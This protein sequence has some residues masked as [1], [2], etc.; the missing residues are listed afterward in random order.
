M[1]NYSTE[2]TELAEHRATL[3]HVDVD[4]QCAITED[5]LHL[6]SLMS[7]S[8]NL[9]VYQLLITLAWRKARL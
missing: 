1:Q 8:K 7:S 9:G 2:F 6:T 3:R 4:S 5:G